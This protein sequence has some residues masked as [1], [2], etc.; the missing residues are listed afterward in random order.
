MVTLLKVHAGPG[1]S[2]SHLTRA[3]GSLPETACW[4]TACSMAHHLGRSKQLASRHYSSASPQGGSIS[5]VDKAAQLSHAGIVQ[6][7]VCCNVAL[8]QALKLICAAGVPARQVRAWVLLVKLREFC[9]CQQCTGRSA[10]Y[11]IVIPRPISSAA[12]TCSPRSG[13]LQQHTPVS[14][15][16]SPSGCCGHLASCG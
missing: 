13:Q 16:P 5:A 12:V 4:H 8:Y 7:N 11:M 14:E 15:V 1:W 6:A 3:S 2:F 10:T 9:T